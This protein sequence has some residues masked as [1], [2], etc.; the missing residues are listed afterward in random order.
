[1]SYNSGQRTKQD[2]TK[3][4]KDSLYKDIYVDRQENWNYS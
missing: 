2:R 3:T 1:M 4:G